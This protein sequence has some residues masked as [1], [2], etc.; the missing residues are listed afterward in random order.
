MPLMTPDNRTSAARRGHAGFTLIELM[1]AVSLGLIVVLAAVGFVASIAKANSEN[2]Q[3]TRLTQELRSISEVLGR[4]IR[5][6]RY[7]ADPIGLI[8]QGG[9]NN[10]DL[11][12]INEA[13]DCIVFGYDEPPD[14]PS[15]AVTV[16]R[17]IRLSG[18]SVFL[19]PTGTNCTGGTALNSQEVQ[20]TDLT[21]TRNAARVDI[22]ITGRLGNAPSGSNLAAVTR[23][24]RQTIYVRSGQVD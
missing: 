19:N 14:P 4:E 10:R 9:G 8:G 20:I 23:T 3:A 18:T 13:A 17:S 11:I 7:V 16:S 12:T 1:V 6:A 15:P 21:F 24:F 22:E 5:R 2:I